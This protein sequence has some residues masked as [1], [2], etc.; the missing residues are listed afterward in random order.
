MFVSEFDAKLILNN[1]REIIQTT[2]HLLKFVSIVHILDST[3]VNFS[4]FKDLNYLKISRFLYLK[5]K[6]FDK[7]SQIP[8]FKSLY[9]VSTFEVFIRSTTFLK[10]LKLI[11]TKIS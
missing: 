4:L 6:V 5:S 1:L 3:Q 11:E 10:S 2:S 9:F 8:Q 7:Y